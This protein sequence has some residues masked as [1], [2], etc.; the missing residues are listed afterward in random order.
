MKDTERQ[1]AIR[2]LGDELDL[3]TAYE[4]IELAMKHGRQNLR[5]A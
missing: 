2:K 3:E 5:S 1:Q 4:E